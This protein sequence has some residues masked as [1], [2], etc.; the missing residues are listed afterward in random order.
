MKNLLYLTSFVLLLFGGKALATLGDV[1]VARPGQ[2][3][4]FDSSLNYVGFAEVGTTVDIASGSN[5]DIYLARADGI[6]HLDG[7][8]NTI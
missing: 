2:I 6:Y 7:S 5:G 8:L 3:L 1:Y 4:R